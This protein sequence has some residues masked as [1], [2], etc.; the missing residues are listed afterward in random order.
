MRGEDLNTMLNFLIEKGGSD[1]HLSVGTKPRVRIHGDLVDIP[2]FEVL[3]SGALEGMLPDLIDLN[4]RTEINTGG[5]YDFAHRHRRKGADGKQ[6]LVRF[7]VNIFRERGDVSGVFRIINDELADYS[8][9]G[10]PQSI[11]DL[12]NEKRGMVLVVGPTG[13]GKSTT[14]ASLL[15]VIR[16]SL[17]E[18]I[19]TLEDPIEYTLWS[20]KALVNQ[21]EMGVDCSSFA[22]GLRAALREDPDVILVGEIR[23]L[24]T[25]QI[26]LSAAET[27]HL[28]LSTLHTLGSV[29]T[30]NR[31]VS[32]F[33]SDQMAMARLQ[34]ADTLLAVVSQQLLPKIGGGRIAVFETLFMSFNA[35]EIIRS[36]ESHRLREFMLSEEGREL[37]CTCMDSNIFKL[38]KQG[39]ISEET[40]IAY[41]LD[42]RA[43]RSLLKKG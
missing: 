15:N 35:R 5:Q 25:A 36:N 38:F 13:S 28:L 26:A 37:G 34:I 39:I 18:H 40:A 9:L 10:I 16:T 1:L 32:M 6:Q 27:G 41:S 3:P 21:R 31:L 2:G 4:S 19:L 24:E 17:P 11:L 20:D 29:E 8:K 12:Y 33:P 30:V 7:R 43:M 14:L 22:D 42:R 23:D